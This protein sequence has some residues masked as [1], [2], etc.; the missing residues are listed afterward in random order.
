MS[1]RMTTGSNH[2]LFN[3]IPVEPY[4]GARG[5][6]FAIATYYIPIPFAA[7][8][9]SS[10]QLTGDGTAVASATVQHTDLPL[11]LDGT[12]IDP[13]VAG[14]GHVWATDAAIGTLSIAASTGPTGTARVTFGN[15]PRRQS[16][17][18]LVV[19]VG[20]RIVGAASG[21]A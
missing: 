13:R 18:V 7:A 16:R 10:L 5:A 8:L 9:V 20:G 3:G 17:I 4:D 21:L 2:F 12:E 1:S 6:P 19:T 15:Q 14:L 11:N